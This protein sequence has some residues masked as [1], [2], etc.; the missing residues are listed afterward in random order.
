MLSG[1]FHIAQRGFSH[2]DLK[3]ENIL[4]DANYNIKIVDFGF[5]CK[6]EGRDGTGVSRSC[7]GTPGYMGPE[8][9]AKKPYQGHVADLFSLG[10]ILFCLVLGYPPFEMA[11][12]KDTFYKH[13]YHN[14]ADLFWKAHQRANPRF[15]FSEGFKELM[16]CLLQADPVNRPSLVDIVGHP[17]LA[18]G[19]MATPE[20]ARI[21]L[22]RRHAV[23]KALSEQQKLADA[24]KSAKVRRSHRAAAEAS[25]TE[26]RMNLKVLDG[27]AVEAKKHGFYVSMAPHTILNQLKGKLAE[28]NTEFA[29]NGPSKLTFD[30]KGND[31]EGQVDD[32]LIA[33]MAGVQV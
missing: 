29:E 13:I 21:E 27:S 15:N 19:P 26:P 3:P 4:L 33:K 6:L 2:R 32:P 22:Q 20:E 17:W 7:V 31:V 16:T 5:A 28:I 24:N 12:P 14:R 11:T 30:V 25:S 23:N 9:L 1:L 10:V 18:Q 8:V